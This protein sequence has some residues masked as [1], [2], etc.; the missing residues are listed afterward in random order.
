MKNIVFVVTNHKE[1]KK[2]AFKSLQEYYGYVN[3]FDWEAKKELMRSTQTVPC[4]DENLQ[5]VLPKDMGEIVFIAEGAKQCVG[6]K[7]LEARDIFACKL[8]KSE[9]YIIE[10]VDC[11]E[12]AVEFLQTDEQNES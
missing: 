4:F 12:S 2:I 3:S 10:D 7:S 8:L 5:P 6:F 11:A 1:F 9:Y